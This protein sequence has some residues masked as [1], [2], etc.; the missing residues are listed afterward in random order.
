[1]EHPGEIW[2][3]V[4][5]NGERIGGIE[6]TKLDLDKVKLFIGAA[7][8]LYR[9]KDGEVEY[10]FQHRSKKLQGN[11]D[12]WDVSAGGHVNLNE[13]RVTAAVR[14]T[15]EEIG[16]KIDSDKLEYAATYLR[17][18]VLVCLYFYDWTGKEDNFSFNDQEVEEVKW[19][20]YKDIKDFM[21]NFKY[22]LAEDEVF[23]YYLKEWTAKIIKKYENL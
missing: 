12:K 3:E 15:Y 10:L 13:S 21:P 22:N 17:W 1:M 14:E 20:K 11:P 5:F 7:V 8:M 18:K 16:A 9:Y 2:Q 6:P 19:I 4:D 23:L